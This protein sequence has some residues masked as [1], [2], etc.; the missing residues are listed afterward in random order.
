LN[1]LNRLAMRH[2]RSK[3]ALRV[4]LWVMAMALAG[5]ASAQP[6]AAK[7]FH[8]FPGSVAELARQ[9]AF[10][11]WNAN[12][13]VQVLTPGLKVLFF[14][15]AKGCQAGAANGPAVGGTPLH[16]QTAYSVTGIALADPPLG[17]RWTPSG[18]TSQCDAAARG[19]SGESFAH[20]NGDAR[21]GGI[22]MYTGVGAVGPVATPFFGP[23]GSGGRNGTGNNA[24]LQGTFVSVV[25]N[26]RRADSVF[27]WASARPDDA[28]LAE[29]SSVQSVAAVSTGAVGGPPSDGVVQV[30]QQFIVAMINRHCATLADGVKR[31]CQLQYVFNIAVFRAGV[32]DWSQV[33]WFQR[34]G[35]WVDPAQGGMPVV[36]G[37]IGPKGVATLDA[38]T[39][40]ELFMS[41]GEPSQHALFAPKAFSSHVSFA[42]LKNAIRIS[43]ATLSGRKAAGLGARDIARYFG[44][45]WD[46][47]NEWAVSSVNV[48]QEAHNPGPQQQAWI[49][50]HVREWWVG[51]VR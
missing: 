17:Q 43:A 31:R 47:A 10:A 8:L 25:F 16:F 26:W 35:V 15:Q 6:G 49:G 14:G 20:V 23:Y 2:W 5:G 32:D 13:P 4:A 1:L 21:A 51:A 50:G 18:Q 30:K 9:G 24:G 28:A 12:I 33:A 11:A 34:G 48:S 27:P 44:P 3:G 46:D 37:P 29:F 39:G 22:G 7:G 41:Q 38:G 40:L 45:R 42:Q 36:R 19:R